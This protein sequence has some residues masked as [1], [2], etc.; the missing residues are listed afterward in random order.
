MTP[1]DRDVK[2][3][4]LIND[5]EDLNKEDKETDIQI[6]P[7]VLENTNQSQCC[8]LEDDY[9][10]DNCLDS[11]MSFST[12]IDRNGHISKSMFQENI[13]QNYTDELQYKL[14]S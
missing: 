2:N 13:H 1:S 10:K 6:E 11:T 5:F 8:R 4:L 9:S 12:D 7:I 14:C 3:N